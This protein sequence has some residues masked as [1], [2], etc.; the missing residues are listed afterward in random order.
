[1]WD[2]L[3]VAFRVAPGLLPGGRFSFGTETVRGVPLRVW[4]SLPA[5]LGDYFRPWFEL[6]ASQEWLVYQDERYT[7]GDVHRMYEALG[8]ALFESPHLNVRRGDRVGIC[9]RNYP[10]F[11][12]A[13]LAITSAGGVA[14]PLNAL[15][16]SEELEY[17]VGDAGCVLVIADPERLERCA[18]FQAKQGFRTILVR[19]DVATVPAAVA[20]GAVAWSAALEEGARRVKANPRGVDQRIKAVGADDETMVM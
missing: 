19:G 3:K 4:K 1:M 8:A 16:N 18:A 12:I 14:V 17:A 10:E 13:F 2:K 7:F 5:A 11:L 6:Y 20:T 9:M 15:W